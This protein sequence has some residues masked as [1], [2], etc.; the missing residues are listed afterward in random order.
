MQLTIIS[1]I[2]NSLYNTLALLLLA[3]L[4]YHEVYTSTP[5]IASD[6]KKDVCN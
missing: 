4:P 6:V 3:P 5:N 1:H 2:H